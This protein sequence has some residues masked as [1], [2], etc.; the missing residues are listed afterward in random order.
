MKAA[1]I[2]EFDQGFSVE[3]VPEPH[4]DRGQ[5]LLRV[6]ATALC[7]SDTKLMKGRLPSLSLPH[8]AGHEFVAEVE[9]LGEGVDG[10]EKG[11]RVVSTIDQVCGVC[12]FCRT[13]RPHH[14][15]SML[16]LGFEIP[17]S[18]AQ[19]TLVRASSLVKVDSEIPVEE[20]C[21]IN[22]AVAVMY[23]A[24]RAKGEVSL[25]DTVVIVGLGG[26]GFQGLQIAK[27]MGARA[28][29]TSRNPEKLRIARELGADLTVN[30]RTESLKEA[31]MD[32]TGGEGVE[33]VADIVGL[34]D[35]IAQD[36]ELL[37][38]GGKVLV[39]GYTHQVFTVPFMGIFLREKEIIGC[40]GATKQELIESVRLVEEGRL[41]P[42]VS[43]R[44]RLEEINEL[45][46]DLLSGKV[47]GRGVMTFQ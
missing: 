28:I 32:F 13:G 20:A 5:V 38:P 30:T 1:L 44:R 31:V 7:V 18:H 39:V 25:G 9:A 42:Y 8:I 4:P 46:S 37:K 22:D 34:E 29:A 24:L 33:V 40:R 47:L 27:L 14:C 35:G 26:L 15:Q 11:D 10:F 45:C 6:L 16:R 41:K 12:T 2:K 17:G 21:V 19:F 23:H 43:N 36:L 3:D